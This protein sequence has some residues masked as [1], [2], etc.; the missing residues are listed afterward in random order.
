MLE[1]FRHHDDIRKKLRSIDLG[2]VTYLIEVA[3]TRA[4]GGHSSF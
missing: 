3:E 2:D 1:H 4:R